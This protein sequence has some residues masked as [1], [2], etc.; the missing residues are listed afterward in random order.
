MALCAVPT[1]SERSSRIV[2]DPISSCSILDRYLSCGTVSGEVNFSRWSC[3]CR[4]WWWWG[5]GREYEHEN[6][7][8]EERMTDY[9]DKED[10]GHEDYDVTTS[11]RERL[12]WPGPYPGS[13]VDHMA[14]ERGCCGYTLCRSHRCIFHT[15]C[16]YTR[17]N[18][19][20]HHDHSSLSRR[21]GYHHTKWTLYLCAYPTHIDR[22]ID[23]SI[24]R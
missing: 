24:D 8:T 23:R 6:E 21:T 7:D 20:T 22:V 13:S 9:E 12:W 1:V 5:G 4:W 2:W 15:C 16:L 17:G 19:S 3:R 14:L 18:S 11:K 10:N